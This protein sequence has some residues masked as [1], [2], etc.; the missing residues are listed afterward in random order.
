MGG[1][2]GCLLVSA[3]LGVT[4]PGCSELRC[5]SP[6]TNFFSSWKKTNLSSLLGC[7]AALPDVDGITYTT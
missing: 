5:F 6:S 7:E 3:G 4:G 1:G 2:A